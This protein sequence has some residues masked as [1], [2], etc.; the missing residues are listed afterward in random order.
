MTY[1]IRT[2]LKLFL[3]IGWFKLICYGISVLFYNDGGGKQL[4]E[5]PLFHVV[6][7]PLF[8]IFVL[9]IHFILYFCFYKEIQRLNRNQRFFYALLQHRQRLQQNQPPPPISISSLSAAS[10]KAA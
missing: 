2:G 3:I 6:L 8:I 1:F 4:P 10:A 5:F 7:A 9:A